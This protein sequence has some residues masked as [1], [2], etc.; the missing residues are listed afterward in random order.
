[1]S[2]IQT[3][4]VTIN[5][6][7]PGCGKTVTFPATEQGQAEALQETAWLHALRSIILPDGRKPSY[8]SD[9]CEIK[10]VA[11]GVHNKLEPKKII[12]A[13]GD[14]GVGLA[15]KAAAQAAATTQ[16][17]KQGSGVTLG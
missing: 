15:A 7:S 16:A 5:C 14:A 8:C 4:F 12:S 2:T 6:D 10:A 3:T 11:T 13:G 17:L 1:L 9:E